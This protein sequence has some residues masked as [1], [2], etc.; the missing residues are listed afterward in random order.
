MSYDFIAIMQKVHEEH[1]FEKLPYEKARAILHEWGANHTEMTGGM[2]WWGARFKTEDDKF[3]V[4]SRKDSAWLGPFKDIEEA[5]SNE[6]VVG[7]VAIVGK[8]INAQKVARAC[9]QQV[10]N[11]FWRFHAKTDL[12]SAIRPIEDPKNRRLFLAMDEFMSHF[13]K[14]LTSEQFQAV[15]TQAGK[16]PQ[17]IKTATRELKDRLAARPGNEQG[18]ERV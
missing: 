8:D 17:W 9:L 15:A 2:M 5:F 12:V 3:F 14:P 1:T 4:Y 18:P 11:K 7:K 6:S 10:T 16:S 13:E